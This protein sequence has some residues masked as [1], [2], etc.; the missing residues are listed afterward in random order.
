MADITKLAI[1]G[2]DGVTAIECGLKISELF[3]GEVLG[4]LDAVY[5]ED[6]GTVMKAV[7]TEAAADGSAKFDGFVA[8]SC[9]IGEP[10]TIFS[11]NNILTKYAAGL[12]PGA[13]Y[14]VSDTAGKIADA[15]TADTLEVAVDTESFELFVDRPIGKA[16][17]TTD[18]RV[19]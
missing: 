2:I 18:I 13:F 11:T 1:A 16:V 12:T 8:K 10:V 15:S 4:A 3:A 17:N 6:D 14:Y 9:A 5:I 19:L 7:S